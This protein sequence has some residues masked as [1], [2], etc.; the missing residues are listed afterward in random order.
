LSALFHWDLIHFGSIFFQLE[1]ETIL[2]DNPRMVTLKADNRSRVKLPDVK[3]GTVFVWEL[4]GEVVKLT[5]VKPVVE[6]EVPVVKMVRRRDGTYRFP[7]HAKPSRKAIIAAIRA[8][9]DSR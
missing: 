7:D 9:R 8:D 1:K 2:E 4:S 5:P 3:P 6:E